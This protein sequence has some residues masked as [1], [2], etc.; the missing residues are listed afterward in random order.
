MIKLR[1]IPNFIEETNIARLYTNVGKKPQPMKNE[2]NTFSI[3][4]RSNFLII[5]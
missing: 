2:N 1:N 4:D 3:E 5:R